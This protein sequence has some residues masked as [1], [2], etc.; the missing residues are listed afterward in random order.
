MNRSEMIM[1]IEAAE[2]L[3]LLDDFVSYLTGTK[4]LDETHFSKLY[5]VVNVISLNCSFYEPG[6]NKKFERF[7][8]ILCNTT[9]TAEEKCEMLMGGDK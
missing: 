7:V 1:L 2:N 6:N 4:G 5:N 9:L 8:K 3:L